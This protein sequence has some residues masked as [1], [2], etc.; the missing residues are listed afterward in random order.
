MGDAVNRG[1]SRKPGAAL[2]A[3]GIAGLLCL[4]AVVVARVDSAP[5][6]NPP[7]STLAGSPANGVPGP[8]SIS[9][10]PRPEASRQ[11]P[12]SPTSW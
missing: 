4:A 1:R 9:L 12:V 7:G 8:A 5:I 11:G 10:P 3:S 2:L 6:G